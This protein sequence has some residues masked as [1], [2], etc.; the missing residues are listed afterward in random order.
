LFRRACYDASEFR[1]WSESGIRIPSDIKH[2]ANVRIGPLGSD[3]E[4]AVEKLNN[5]RFD[6][7]PLALRVVRQP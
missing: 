5:A 3:H 6:S 2:V 4:Q 7:K 1:Q